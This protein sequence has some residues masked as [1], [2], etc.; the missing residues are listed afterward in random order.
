TGTEH[1]SFKAWLL[2]QTRWRVVDQF[3]KRDKFSLPPEGGDAV[4][5]GVMRRSDDAT[6]TATENRIPDPASPD[7]ERGWD[8]EWEKHMLRVA[9]ERLKAAASP[10]QFQ[11]FDL[12]ALQGLS[13]AQTAKTVGASVMGV[14]MATSRLRRRLQREI[15]GLEQRA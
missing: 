11:M 14:H 3:R 5:R 4:H 13:A 6:G 10:K 15:A 12:H 9:L 8:T 2:R 1:G 7:L